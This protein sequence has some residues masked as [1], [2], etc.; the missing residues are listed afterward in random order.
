M[1]DRINY[2]VKPIIEDRISRWEKNSMLAIERHRVNDFI[3]NYIVSESR[4]GK[5]NPYTLME[6]PKPYPLIYKDRIYYL[7]DEEERD[8]VMRNPKTLEQNEA[9]PKDVKFV[10]II[11]IIGK[12]KSG[13]STLALNLKEKYGFKIITMEEIIEDFVKEHE[14]SDIKSI[15]HEIRTGKVL[16]D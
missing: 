14:D 8:Y 2:L 16:S 9:V 12:T 5:L 13:K 6:N 11:F 1:T 3:N 4:F 15:M 10:P 7:R